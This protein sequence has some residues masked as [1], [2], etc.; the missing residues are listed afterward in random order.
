MGQFSWMT[1]DTGEQIGSQ[2]EN[3]ITVT[4][5]DDKGNTWVESQYD[6]YGVFGGKDYYDLIA[7]MNGYDKS[8][9]KDFTVEKG[10]GSN[11][12]PDELRTVGIMISSQIENKHA[13]KGTY[14]FPGLMEHYNV[15]ERKDHDFSIEAEHD[16]NQSWY[17]DEEGDVFPYAKGGLTQH[18]NPPYY[19]VKL[20]NWDRNI[21]RVSGRFR[22]EEEAKNKA[23]QLKEKYKG[24]SGYFVEITF[25]DEQYN[26]EELDFAKGGRVISID[27]LVKKLERAYPDISMRE[28]E[29][30][31]SIFEHWPTDRNGDAL[32]NQNWWEFDPQEKKYK[33]G[34]IKHFYNFL[35]RNGY[36]VEFQNPE[37]VKIWKHDNYAKGGY[38]KIG[39]DRDKAER[40]LRQSDYYGKYHEDEDELGGE[41]GKFIFDKKSD[42][43]DAL[44]ELQTEG[45]NIIDTNLDDYAKGGKTKHWKDDKYWADYTDIG[46]YSMDRNRSN[47]ISEEEFYNIGKD[48]VDTQFKGDIGNAW[49]SIVKGK[50]IHKFRKGRHF[51]KGGEISRDKLLKMEGDEIMDYYWENTTNHYKSLNNKELSRVY[52][53]WFANEGYSL[54]ELESVERDE[55]IWDLIED[56]KRY[57]KGYENTETKEDKEEVIDELFYFDDYAKGGV[58]EKDQQ[59]IIQEGTE[60]EYVDE[61]GDYA[62]IIGYQEFFGRNMYYIWFNGKMVH[63]SITYKS[64]LRKLNQLK[65]DYKLEYKGAK[66]AKG[67]LIDNTIHPYLLQQKVG[68]QVKT[69][70]GLT[71]DED[72]KITDEMLKKN[73]QQ[74]SVN[75]N[76]SISK[77][78]NYYAKGGSIR[79]TNNSPLLRYTNY[80]D[81]WRL[82]LLELNPLRNQDG[83]KYKGNYK[84]GISRQGPGTKQ[85]VWQFETLKE[86]DKKYDEL[87]YFS[88]T[89][90][91]IEKKGKIE[92]NYA[93][94]G[95]VKKKGNEMIMGGLAG[96]L[97]GIFLNK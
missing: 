12:K 30:S 62:A 3:T 6:G 1:M 63:S 11:D 24:R 52:R 77:D 50:P 37:H 15:E 10:W 70:K 71:E 58:T 87:V 80:E 69:I 65:E 57:K 83:L 18:D 44:Y 97:L 8:N 67:G 61:D 76:Y 4:M 82:N 5:F 49:D 35:D 9:F 88:K 36:W 16:P 56:E 43:H 23:K 42:G 38:I 60:I 40:F 22:T 46:I 73:N 41:S 64:M 93:K 94:G 32:F 28:N 51:R 91:K 27:R 2:D 84:Y 20:I 81:G 55:M 29:D 75:I 89:Y 47:S 34:V 21:N 17:V 92:A 59:A 79:R 78:P 39:L 85:E 25:Y 90:S 45:I 26:A 74:V 31:I 33:T 13:P 48:I 72:R 86:A 54:E 14:K 95:E 68:K 66:Y 19:S 96:L 7:E 53:H